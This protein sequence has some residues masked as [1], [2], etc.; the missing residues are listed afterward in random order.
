MNDIKLKC[1]LSNYII[2]YVIF[3]CLFLI[4]E[5]VYF[6]IRVKKKDKF[7]SKIIVY[8]N[9]FFLRKYI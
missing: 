6:N 7:Y 1:V 4:L 3:K 8:F 9:M 5:N 2:V